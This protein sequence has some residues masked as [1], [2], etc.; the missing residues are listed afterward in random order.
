[1][2]QGTQSIHDRNHHFNRDSGTGP[3]SSILLEFFVCKAF[4]TPEQEV[5]KFLGTP[6]YSFDL[7]PACL[8]TQL[9][10][11]QPS[12]N[13]S[14]SQYYPHYRPRSNAKLASAEDVAAT[15]VFRQ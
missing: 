15:V 11:I 7:E 13:V 5:A 4:L 12:S 10:T 6:I 8:S 1:L 3:Q 9:T 2:F 14:P